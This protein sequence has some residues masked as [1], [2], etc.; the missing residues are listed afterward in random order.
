MTQTFTYPNVTDELLDDLVTRIMSVGNPLKVVLFGSRARGD[1][2][3]DSDL[4]ILIIE[5][6]DA[7]RYRRAPSYLRALVGLFPAKD[8]VVWT[9]AEIAEWATV[10]NAFITLA[11][12]EGRVLYERPG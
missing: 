9:P 11:L 2:R 1:A 6:S 5:E 4:D 10:P 3:P 7:P 12:H 8:V